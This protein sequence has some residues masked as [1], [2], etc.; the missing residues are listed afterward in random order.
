MELTKNFTLEE[1]GFGDKQPNAHEI[2]S[3]WTLCRLVLQPLRER[4]GPIK[5]TSGY[6]S[7]AHNK[8]IG[9]SK[10][11]QHM[12]RQASNEQVWDA[13]VDINF[14][15]LMDDHGGRMDAYEWAAENLSYGFSQLIW[16][17]MTRH[18]HI[19]LVNDR[20]QG[21]LLVKHDGGYAAIKDASEIPDWDDRV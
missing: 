6:R 4:F 10:T 16:Y 12:F 14:L 19:G 9:G 21:E 17:T 20:K 2:R 7:P 1:F 15:R 13:A 3:A 8:K 18:F 5:I 11:S